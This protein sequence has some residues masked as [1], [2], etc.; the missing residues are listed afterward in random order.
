MA[1]DKGASDYPAIDSVSLEEAL[2]GS[3]SPR[4]TSACGMDKDDKPANAVI[5]TQ[6]AEEES[7]DDV[8]AMQGAEEEAGSVPATAVVEETPNPKPVSHEPKD[9]VSPKRAEK[10]ERN[11]TG[12]AGSSVEMSWIM[13]GERDGTKDPVLEMLRERVALAESAA[14]EGERGDAYFPALAAIR[15]P[16]VAS[17]YGV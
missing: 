7:A 6:A 14:R 9:A 15:S 5:M 11:E 16:A 1:V 2:S 17:R 3:I 12:P 8:R 4:S 10:Q 13:A